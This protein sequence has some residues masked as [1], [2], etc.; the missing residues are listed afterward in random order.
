M[1]LPAHVLLD[2]PMGQGQLIQARVIVDLQGQSAHPT[3]GPV[4]T[5][6]DLGRL[7]K[8]MA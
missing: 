1:L 3:R 5:K 6:L 7:P 8:T 4:L 2:A